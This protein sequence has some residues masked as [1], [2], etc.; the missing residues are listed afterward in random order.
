MTI[1]KREINQQINTYRDVASNDF[2]TRELSSGILH[3]QTRLTSVTAFLHLKLALDCTIGAMWYTC[4]DRMFQLHGADSL[5]CFSLQWELDLQ[6]F[7]SRIARR[8]WNVHTKDYGTASG[9]VADKRVQRPWLRS[10]NGK[11]NE[12]VGKQQYSGTSIIRTSQQNNFVGAETVS[13]RL[14]LTE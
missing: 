6:D 14:H 13:V 10:D 2:K 4:V 5:C 9:Q 3:S 12:K 7:T 8:K 11:D 1:G